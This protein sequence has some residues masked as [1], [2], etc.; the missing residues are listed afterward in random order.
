MSPL[1][2]YRCLK[3]SRKP[4]GS[5]RGSK[6]SGNWKN[7]VWVAAIQDSKRSRRQLGPGFPQEQRHNTKFF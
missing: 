6:F 2:D 5:E 7:S 1:L 4:T 3:K